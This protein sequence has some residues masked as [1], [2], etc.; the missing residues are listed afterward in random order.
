MTVDPARAE[1]AWN[2]AAAHLRE[3]GALDAATAPMAV[4]HASYYAMFHAARAVLI[5]TAGSAPKRHDRVIQEFGRTVGNLDAALREAGR[6]FNQAKDE[7]TSADYDDTSAPSPDEAR[8]MLR[9]ASAFLDACAA[10][11]RFGAR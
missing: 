2:K 9:I 5:R 8:E 10:H 4:I 11:F 1:A 6:S 3:A 7:R